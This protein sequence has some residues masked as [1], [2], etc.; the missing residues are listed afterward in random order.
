M[1]EIDNMISFSNNYIKKIKSSQ[2]IDE[3]LFGSDDGKKYD[4]MRFDDFFYLRDDKE[5]YL[6]SFLIQRKKYND[7]NYHGDYTFT[8]LKKDYLK[9]TLFVAQLKHYKE[10]LSIDIINGYLEIKSQ[11][12]KKGDRFASIFET[13]NFFRAQSSEDRTGYGTIWDWSGGVGI[14]EESRQYGDASEFVI[15]GIVLEKK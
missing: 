12:K 11:F 13:P 2:I 10:P 1:V 15:I 8:K 5:L 4:T 7:M 9:D 3:F 14:I 6:G